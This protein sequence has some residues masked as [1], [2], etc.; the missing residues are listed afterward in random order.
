MAFGMK[1][2]EII[3]PNVTNFIQFAVNEECS[4]YEEGCK[5]YVPFLKSG[6]P[7][8]HFEYAT[9]NN[10]GGYPE[11][12]STYQNL[13]NFNSR[14]LLDYY[15]LRNS[16]GNPDFVTAD[17]GAQFSTVIKL[18][19]LGGWAM[20]CD[21]SYAETPTSQTVGGREEG[22]NARGGRGGRGSDA[23]ASPQPRPYNQPAPYYQ[24]SPY[25]APQSGY[26]PQPY[27]QPEPN[28]G[29][30]DGPWWDFLGLFGG[31]SG[32]GGRD[33]DDR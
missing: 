1:N 18:L 24:P 3:L 15:C 16:Y 21:G 28:Q 30:G 12:R 20:Y 10:R 17:M 19:D 27:Q 6:K 7:V 14:Q 5:Q 23:P 32:R 26:Q 8:F 9:V 29:R 2:A 31:R 22:G 33:E 13:T 11:I 4:T 25:Q